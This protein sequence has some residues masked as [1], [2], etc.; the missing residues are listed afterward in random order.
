[1]ATAVR[2]RTLA[3]F[4]LFTPFYVDGS[5]PPAPAVTGGLTRTVQVIG[6]PILMARP[7]AGPLRELEAAEDALEKRLRE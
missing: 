4:G 5:R 3:S 2:G 1:M 6:D 7:E